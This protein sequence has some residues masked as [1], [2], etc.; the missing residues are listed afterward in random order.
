MSPAEAN[1]L[2]ILPK[3]MDNFLAQCYNASHE[4]IGSQFSQE[5]DVPV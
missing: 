3:K 4:L 2:E 1:F 5:M